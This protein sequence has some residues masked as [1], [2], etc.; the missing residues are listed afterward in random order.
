MAHKFTVCRIGVEWAVR[1]ATGALYAI[2]TK[3]SATCDAA[4]VLA[5]RTGGR[6]ALTREAQE[7]LAS[8]GLAD[9]YPTNED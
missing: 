5:R 8:L 2:S 6:I 1:D 3:L 7:R 4:D 9:R